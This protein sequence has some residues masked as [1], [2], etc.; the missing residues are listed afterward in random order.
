MSDLSEFVK[1]V[2]E[3]KKKK[4]VELENKLKNPQSDLANLFA[5]LK[6]IHEETKDPL[7][8]DELPIK[9]GPPEYVEKNE[10]PVNKIIEDIKLS[11]DD[12]S[13]LNEF[14][15]LFSGIE[16]IEEISEDK[17]EEEIE[18]VQEILSKEIEELEEVVLE[19]KTEEPSEIIK[20]SIKTIGD[21]RYDK[22]VKNLDDYP[23]PF[24]AEPALNAELAEFK[25]KINEHLHKIGFASSGGG[26]IGSIKDADDINIDSQADGFILKYNATTGQYVSSEPSETSL[27]LLIDGTDGSSTNTGDHIE[28]S[29]TDASSTNAGDEIVL[30][31]GVNGSRDFEYAVLQELSSSIIPSKNGVFDLGSPTKRFGSLFLLADTI[32]LDGATIKSDGSGQITISADGA[33]FPV[34]SKDT[35]GKE[36]LVATAETTDSGVLSGQTSKDV[37]LFTQASGL[38]TAAATF[39]FAK[40]LTNRSVYTNSGHTF[41]LS[42][43]DA[44]ADKS[45]ELFEF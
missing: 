45:V 26:G 32:D 20:Q 37:S 2:S 39:T 35:A 1:L 40:T 21:I 22:K 25:K 18:E 15:D 16:S 19:E 13:K 36:L 8:K 31:D 4:E 42:N 34:G 6:T 9:F 14:S 5:E 23:K 30:E 27:R 28:L 43:G 17:N 33:I 29:G 38:T 3:E 12:K 7:P 10:S 44:R 11:D 24:K 41:I